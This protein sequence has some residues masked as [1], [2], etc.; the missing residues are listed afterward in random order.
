MRITDFKFCSKCSSHKHR[1]EFCKNAGKSDGLSKWCRKCHAA[2]RSAN[3]VPAI[4][5]YC[6]S[7]FTKTGD[8]KVFCSN[9]C[10]FNSTRKYDLERLRALADGGARLVD[11]SRELGVSGASLYRALRTNKLYAIWA[12]KRAHK[13]AGVDARE[14]N[15]PVYL[16]GSAHHP[17]LCAINSLLAGWKAVTSTTSGPPTTSGPFAES[18]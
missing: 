4:C 9:A 7:E 16:R 2:H 14:H 3:G 17:K 10:R 1:N 6:A 11:M 15:A 8:R 5:K 12:A 13:N 18:A